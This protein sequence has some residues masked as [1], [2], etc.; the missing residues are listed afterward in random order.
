MLEHNMTEKAKHFITTSGEAKEIVDN[1]PLTT[2]NPP[3]Q[4]KRKTEQKFPLPTQPNNPSTQIK[5]DGSICKLCSENHTLRE[6]S[7]FNS[8]GINE[9]IEFVKKHEI[10]Y[11]CLAVGH[12][13]Q[14]CRSTFICRYCGGRHNSL[15]HRPNS[16]I[17]PHNEDNQA[18]SSSNTVQSFS[19]HTQSS[20]PTPID[21]RTK[22][23]GTAVLNVEV[24]GE[25]FPARALIDPASDF[26]FITDKLRKKLHLPTT[27]IVA[28]ISGLNEIVSARSTKLCQVS[29]RSNTHNNFK[30]NIQ[31][32]VVKTLTKNLPTQSLNPT[33]IKDLEDIQLAD[34]KFYES[35]PIDFIIGSD[36]YPQILKSGVRKDLLNTLI[37]QET[38]FGWILTGP[39][40]N[41]SNTQPLVSYFSSVTLDKVLTKFWEIEDI[42]TQPKVSE[43]S[44]LCEETF[45]TTTRRLPNGRYQVN[46]PFIYPPVELG[47]SR[48]VAMAQFLRNEKSLI[49]KPELKMEYDNVLQEYIELGH[50]RHIKYNPN[51]SSNTHY[52]LPHH[53]V[54]KLDRVTTKVRVVF[55]ASSKTS[56]SNS[57]NDT[58]YTGPTLQQDL[59]VLILKW[60]FYKIVYN[61]DITKMYRQIMLN[62]IHTPFQRILFRKSV[63]EAIQDYELQT[64]TFGVNC[65]PYLAIR[66]LHE[67]AKDI[68]NTHPIASQTL[69]NNMYVDDVLA[70][71][72]TIEEAKEGQTQLI[73]ALDSA[74]FPLRKWI[75]NTREL[76]KDLPEDH[77]LD[78]DLLNLPES[79]NAKTLGIRW[80]AKEDT[81]FFN[82]PLI[83]RKSAYTKRTVLSD[84]ARLFDPAGWLAPIVISAKII[85]QQ[86]WQD[87]TAW[88]E[89]LKPLTLIKWQKFLQFYD[90]INRIHIPRW[91]NFSPSAKIE[92]HGFSDASEKA[93]S[94]CLYARVTPIDGPN[95]VTL[96]FAKTRVAPIKV[97]SLP[98]LELCGA[99]LL[100]NMTHNLLT[101]LNLPLHQTYFWTD[102]SIVLAWLSKHPN[103]W[104]TFVA[105][106]VSTIIQTVGVENWN[107][108]ASHD[109]P[110][111]VASR[112]CNA[113]EL[114]DDTLWWNGP[115]WLKE[116]ASKWPTTNK[117]FITQAEAKVSQSF[118]TTVNTHPSLVNTNTENP[119]ILSRFSKLSKALRK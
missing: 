27:P 68:Q 54:V 25:L 13:I 91:I 88:D 56:N 57:L 98:K 78:V 21:D 109:N 55:N 61:A 115:S 14:A 30:L 80:N 24:Q 45:M 84:I 116:V 106:R 29:L 113:D 76:L 83:E 95:S 99:V 11:N 64:V 69:R 82:V 18:S 117:H 104:N 9:R 35:R 49:K 119:D 37:A 20:K 93:Y 67:L 5:H 6:C 28:E 48:H 71:G 111:D 66:T 39:I 90:N 51:T 110:A 85:M 43:E 44:S 108:V 81:F 46:L 102:S 17:N 3:T 40:Q 73:A 63:N 52:Y 34:Q 112:G 101:Q 72:H 114:K 103:S 7:S 4:N 19:T 62:P 10:C 65:A 15:L 107:H 77:L 47:N 100:A 94:A 16:R 89:C 92:F 87:N 22:L 31:A 2:H 118:T 74:G 60:R 59:V 12:V 50:M 70:G 86:I 75:S 8:L 105:N 26:S 96:L 53:A 79:N 32:I 58:L 1:A 33:L 42:S 23:L 41:T 36:F 97:I 38:E